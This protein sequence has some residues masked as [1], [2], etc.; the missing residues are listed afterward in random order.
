MP[1][2]TGIIG[3]ASQEKYKQDLRNMLNCML[4]EPFYSSGTFINDDICV[5]A[6]W[7]CH[8]ESFCDCMPVWNEKK[9]V[10][11]IF[12]GENFTDLE[13]FDQ[14]KAKHHKFDNSNASYLIHLYEEKGIDFLHVLN[15]W[16]SGLLIDLQSNKVFLFN[17]R[18]GMQ[19]I[20]YYESKDTFYFASEAKALLKVC[21]MLR[22]LD[23]C[24]LGEL[25]ACGCT[26]EDRTLF[27]KIFLLPIASAW[28]IQK[29]VVNKNKYFHAK[30][31]EDQTWLEKEFFYDKLRETFIRILPRYFRGTKP[32]GI[33]L[34]GG[35]DTRMLMANADLPSGKYPCYTFASMYRDCNDVKIAQKIAKAMEQTHQT[36]PVD[37]NFLDNFSTHAEKTVYVTDG[38]LDVSGAPENFIN[39]I[40]RGIAPIR[41]TGNY[42]SEVLR[43]IRWLRAGKPNEN[44]Y[45]P[46]LNTHAWE[47]FN[48]LEKINRAI[49][50]PLTFTLFIETPWLENRKLVCEQTQL[51]LRTPYMDNDLVALMYRAPVGARNSK[52]LSLRLI[53]DGNMALRNIP[54]DRGYGGNMRFPFSNFAQMYHEFLFKAEYAYNYGMPQWLARFDYTLK[55]MHLEKLF[56]GRHKFAHF[57]VWYRDEL[58]DY[59]KAILLDDKTLNRPYLNRK[60]VED[61]VVGH[62]KGYQNYTTE[63][64]QLLTLE[65]IQRLLIEQ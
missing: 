39:N 13:L 26:L 8:K 50:N 6:G 17:D 20:F 38:Y 30:V 63:I 54:T 46:D 28:A 25:F 40:A 24:G 19:K 53:A 2:I 23:M 3:Q 14:L 45:H 34:T 16:F 57:R 56:L 22:E 7:V 27:K 62:T 18:Y 49:P 33:S 60:A 42:G 43:D 29:G 37:S 59:V 12:F 21:P 65:L 58:A 41:M 61:V 55:F 36:I 32:I 35:L 44:I 48:T 51:T 5:Y 10:A 9:N 52:E 15:G 64:T 11:L 31:W 47:T 1:G 4:H